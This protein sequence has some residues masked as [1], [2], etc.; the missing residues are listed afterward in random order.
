MFVLREIVKDDKTDS[1]GEKD[2]GCREL[3]SPMC[4][5]VCMCIYKYEESEETIHRDSTWM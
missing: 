2:L 4:M 3:R 5:S 1:S